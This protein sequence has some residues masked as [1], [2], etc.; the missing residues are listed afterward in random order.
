MIN[1]IKAH[2]PADAVM[3]FEFVIG[4]E[5]DGVGVA[6]LV[7]GDAAPTEPG[8]AVMERAEKVVLAIIGQVGGEFAAGGGMLHFVAI[9]VFAGGVRVDG[10]GFGG[11]QRVV[12][13]GVAVKLAG[14]GNE[15]GGAHIGDKKSCA[16][17]DGLGVTAWDFGKGAG[18]GALDC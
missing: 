4:A 10:G 1:S 2:F 17:V 8:E 13:G 15:A 14:F 18:Y 16:L 5:G 3:L 7:V 12:I 6:L 9:G 11:L